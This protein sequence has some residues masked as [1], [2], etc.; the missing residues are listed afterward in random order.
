MWKRRLGQTN[1]FVTPVCWGCGPLG[2]LPQFMGYEV[3]ENQAVQIVLKAFDSSVNFLDTSSRVY[4]ESERRIG[5]AIKARGDFPAGFVLATKADRNL[6]TNDFSAAQIRKSITES[7]NL[8][9]LKS[10]DLV[11]LHDPEYHPLYKSDR[12]AAMG[13]LLGRNGAVSELE[14]MRS[15]G[16]ISYIGISGGPIDMM[17]EFVST[18][19]FEV[20]ITHS[21]WNLLWQTANPLIELSY[22]MG[23]GIVNAAVYASGIL[24]SGAIN[25]ARAF[26][27]P[28]TN[29]VIE[30]VQSMEET[31]QKYGVPLAAAALQ[32]SLNDKRITSTAIGLSKPQEIDEAIWLAELPLPDEL[33]SKLAPFAIKSK[34][35]FG[36]S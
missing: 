14:K 2:N 15:E 6:H 11:Y 30:L 24:A 32:F 17:L 18:G 4:G 22:K 25:G 13:E 31:C 23:I 7:I 36:W 12:K 16:L 9:N 33:W 29:E 21:R 10:L 35:P 8:L 27:K 5:M 19:R 1:L 3:N 26:Y 20:V 28:A 34:D